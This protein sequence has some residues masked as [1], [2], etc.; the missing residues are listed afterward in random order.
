MAAK[1]EEVELTSRGEL[2]HGQFCYL[3]I[4]AVDVMQS[5]AF[6][7]K[8][9][10]WK[11]ERPYPSFEAPGLIGQWVDDRPPAAEAGLLAWINVDR[12]DDALELVRT[13]GGQV[14]APPSADGPRWLATIRDPGGNVLGLAQ[15][16]PR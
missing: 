3:Q 16:G 6:Y 7:E 11:I 1:D 2:A 14:L 12:I 5:A 13:N 4:P 9:F 15:H 10:G 8:I